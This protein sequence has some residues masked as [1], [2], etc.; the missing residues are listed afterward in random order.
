[1]RITITQCDV[2]KYVLRSGGLDIRLKNTDL[3]VC[4]PQCLNVASSPYFIATP[5]DSDIINNLKRVFPDWEVTS[6]D[7][8]KKYQEDKLKKVKEELKG[9]DGYELTKI[10]DSDI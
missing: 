5:T 4:S 2:C 9:L 1:M 10:G 3:L 7:Y 6:P 8:R